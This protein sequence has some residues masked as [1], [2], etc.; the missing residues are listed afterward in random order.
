M[1][2]KSPETLGNVHRIDDMLTKFTCAA[3]VC[4]A[5][6]FQPVS[7]YGCEN[8]L[9]IVWK[10]TRMLAYKGARFCSGSERLCATG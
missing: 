5:G 9:H 2:G 10:N 4:A 7:G 1:L 6:R 3:I 8:G